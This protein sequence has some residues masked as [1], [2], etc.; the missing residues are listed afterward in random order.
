VIGGQLN[1]GLDAPRLRVA[2]R[3]ALARGDDEGELPTAEAPAA[4]VESEAAARPA[5]DAVGTR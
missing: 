2:H 5:R 1:R 3:D 4:A